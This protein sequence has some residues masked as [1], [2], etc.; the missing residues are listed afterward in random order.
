MNINKE[1]YKELKDLKDAFY[2]VYERYTY[3]KDFRSV[4]D[5]CKYYPFHG[6]LDETYGEGGIVYLKVVEDIYTNSAFDA[7]F[8]ENGYLQIDLF[9]IFGYSYGSFI[10]AKQAGLD[11]TFAWHLDEIPESPVYML[12]NLCGLRRHSHRGKDYFYPFQSSRTY[13][14][15]FWR[16]KNTIIMI[17]LQFQS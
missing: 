2:N 10:L 9:D 17:I 12:P 5:S 6:S 15:I 16:I 11:I 3:N 7:D 4:M 14:S 1:I 8:D 13:H